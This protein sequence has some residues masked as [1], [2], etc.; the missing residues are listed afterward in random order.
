[1]IVT[2]LRGRLV[3]S[4]RHLRVLLSRCRLVLS[5]SSHCAALLL[6]RRAGWLLRCRRLVVA[7]PLVAPPSHPL[8][9]PSHSR[10][11]VVLSLR[12]PPVASS[13][14]LVVTSPL[15]A[16]SHSRPIVVLSLRRPLVA[17]S[18]RLVVAS[19]LVAPPSCFLVAPPHSRPIVVLSLRCPLVASS[20]RRPRRRVLADHY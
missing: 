8:I 16:P 20:L 4:L 18:R 14:Q 15:I 11:I 5:S 1:V 10:P 2:A 3:L 19:P 17:S 13:R 12:R 7:L 9:A 6:P